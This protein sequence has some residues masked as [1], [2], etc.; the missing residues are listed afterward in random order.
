VLSNHQAASLVQLLSAVYSVVD[1]NSTS[2]G[3]HEISETYLKPQTFRPHPFSRI[4]YASASPLWY[5]SHI[6]FLAFLLSRIL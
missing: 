6:H 4:K 1:L 2:S 5:D 3:R